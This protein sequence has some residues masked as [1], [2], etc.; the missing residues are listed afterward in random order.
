MSGFDTTPKPAFLLA[1]QNQRWTVSGALSE[2]VDNSFGDARGNA[3]KV[4]IT[5]D[6]AGRVIDV[7][8]DGH[9]M[10]AIGRIFQLGNTIGRSPNDIGRY[11][12]GGTMAVLW[13][14]SRVQVW[15]L[16]DGRVGYDLVDWKQQIRRDAFPVISDDW[17]RAT[18]A[19][20]PSVLIEAG[21]GT[22]IRLHLARE[23]TFSV[24]NVVR[25]LSETYAPAVRM[26]KELIWQTIAKNGGTTRMG[27]PLPLP[28]DPTRCVKF[29][30]TLETASGEHLGV[31]GQ[32][33]IVEGWPQS[34][35]RVAV[36]FGAR[37]LFH[38]RDCYSSGDQR[39][40]ATGVTGWL[41][42]KA[43]WQPYLATTKD[44]IND[45]PLWETLMG[46]VF[47]QIEPLLGQV[48]S[49]EFKV[50]FEEI[51]LNLAEVLNSP[52]IGPAIT[53]RAAQS[54]DGGLAGRGHGSSEGDGGR[55]GSEPGG[56]DEREE[57]DKTAAKPEPAQ[58]EII[59]ST[60]SDNEMEGLLCTAQLEGNGVLVAVNK[61]HR[62]V[63]EALRSEP[64]NRM[65]LHLLVIREIAALI[66][67]EQRLMNRLFGRSQ[68]EQIEAKIDERSREAFVA[69]L[70]IDQIKRVA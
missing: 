49:E 68:R 38:T 36:S 56:R 46:Y 24:S 3:R 50:I 52:L 30:I 44:A 22:L 32:V 20:T 40:I 67:A 19:N 31:E 14:S 33:F 70:L 65:A 53:V 9:G 51:A 59:I 43:G 64:I 7:F 34:R 48:E 66:V 39:Y 57:G 27:N 60:A 13:L 18:L 10:D 47:T 63:Q 61:D 62:V 12:S 45:T 28:S 42:L 15:T 16:K 21:H 54:D 23:R 2:L 41:D 69:R 58:S 25:D 35:S 26:G 1:M 11:G 29:D 37:M 55:G 8:D 17:Q 6:V 5:Y 4:V